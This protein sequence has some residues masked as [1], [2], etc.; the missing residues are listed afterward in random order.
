M[1]LIIRFAEKVL[2]GFGFGAGMGIAYRMEGNSI[3]KTCF[4]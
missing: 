4:E 1:S 2:F 3:D